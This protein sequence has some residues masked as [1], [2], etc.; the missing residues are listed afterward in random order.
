MNAIGDEAAIAGIG[1]TPFSPSLGR[2]EFYMAI[3]AIFA[4]CD[5][6]GTSPRAIDGVVRV[7]AAFVP[8]SDDVTLVKF[9]RAPG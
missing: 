4:A 7:E 9:R 2:S 8:V 3:E 1:Q 6:A 5:D